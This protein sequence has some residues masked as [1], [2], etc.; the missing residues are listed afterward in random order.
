MVL[1]AKVITPDSSFQ[2]DFLLRDVLMIRDRVTKLR[3]KTEAL[4]DEM[5]TLALLARLKKRKDNLALN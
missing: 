4:R 1:L 3:I 2:N 5:N